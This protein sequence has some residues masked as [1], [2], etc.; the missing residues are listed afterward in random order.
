MPIFLT[1]LSACMAPP[2]EDPPPSP[3][4]PKKTNPISQRSSGEKDIVISGINL[5]PVF[6]VFGIWGQLLKLEEL[7][8]QDTFFFFHA[9]F[10]GLSRYICK[11]SCPFF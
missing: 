3:A 2:V 9:T 5:G 8:F 10:P 6:G 7:S 11:S 4:H 1:F